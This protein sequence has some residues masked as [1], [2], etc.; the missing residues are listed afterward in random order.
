MEPMIKRYQ[1]RHRGTRAQLFVQE[2]ELARRNRLAALLQS[3]HRSDM[4]LA[5]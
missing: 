3:W 4:K 5:G 2:E 1:P